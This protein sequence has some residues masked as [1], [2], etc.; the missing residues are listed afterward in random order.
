MEAPLISPADLYPTGS[1]Q[2]GYQLLDVRAPIEIA[3]GALPEA[4]YEPLL[5]DA[6]RHLVGLRYREAGQQ[7]AIDLGYELVT[8]DLPRRI[9]V[10]REICEQAPT[11]VT[12][13]RGGLRSKLVSEFIDRS[14]VVRVE[15]GYKAIR[16]YLLTEMEKRL[17]EMQTLVIA[18]LTGSGKTALLQT[19]GRKRSDRLALDLEHHANHRGSTFGQRADPQ[20]SQATFENA[21]AAQLTLTSAQ[22]LLVE[23]ES[24]AI[25]QVKLPQ[26]LY[27]TIQQSPLL[28]IEEPLES[29]IAQIHRDY[30]LSLSDAIGIEAAHRYFESAFLRL[31]KRLGKERLHRCLGSL[32]EATRSGSWAEQAA[33]ETWIATVLE[34]H[35]DPLYHKSLQKLARPILF[36]G[37]RE[38]CLTWLEQQPNPSA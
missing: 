18:G 37:S 28:L 14:N 6:E 25:G 13:W 34:H 7:A 23:D 9:A 29:R 11:A 17:P 8:A 32:A 15:G 21:L 30:V 26:A 16:R 22:L 38:E 19:V 3:R 33:H 2:A 36:K 31:K 27:H 10:W 24:H 20:P 12:C 1:N 4:N 35:Y 5:S